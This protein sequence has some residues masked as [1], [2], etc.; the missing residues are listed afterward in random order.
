MK[1]IFAITTL[2][3][4]INL[5]AQDKPKW[6]VNIPPGK[7][8]EVS[9]TANE[10]TWMNLD[11]SPDGSTIAFDM[12]GDIYTMPISGG[13]A[14]AIRTGLAWEVQPRW[15]PDG[16]K[17]LF[18][19]DS[20]GGDNI[21][22]MDADGNNVKQITKESFRLLNNA[23][24]MPDGQYIIAR[25][26]FTSGR[27][28]GAGEMWMYHISGGDGIQ[29]TKR[30]NDQQDV[31]E[32]TISPDG[33]MLYYSE[34]VY[35]GGYFQ[36]NK[37]PNSEIFVI[38]SYN[39]ETGE[40]KRVTGGPGGACRPQISNKGDKIAYV[41]RVREKS[42]LYIYEIST[43]REWAIYDGL[44]KDQQEAWTVFGIY[45]GFDWMP[46]DKEIVIWAKGKIIKI[47][48]A[49]KKATDIPFT[50]N[51]KHK[52]METVQFENKA[53]EE[54]FDLKVLRNAVTSPDGN[55]LVFS[56][57]G[58]LYFSQNGKT[59]ERL[60][61]GTDFEAEPQFNAKGDQIVYV[62]WNDESLGKI[63]IY[64]LTTKKSTVV[65]NDPAI[66]RTPS[67][68]PDGRQIVYRK[69]GGNGHQGYQYNTNSGIYTAVV[70]GENAELI[71]QEG[72]K[73]MFSAD[74]SEIFFTTGGFLFGSIAKAFKKYSFKT[75]KTEV[76][77]NTSYTTNF[78]PSPDN[79]WV[80]FT[81]LYK[82]YIAPMPKTGQ[83]IGLSAKTKA[84]P[85]AQVARDAGIN[86]HW[87]ADSKSLHWTLGNEYFTES[88]NRRFLFLEGA[89]D[90]IP[91]IDT[92]GTKISLTIKTDKP[93]GKIAF[94]NA[95]II[96][97]ENDKVIKNGIVLV[98]ENIIKYVGP[99]S[100]VKL[101]NNTKT[102]DVKGKTIMPG[103]IDVHAHLGAFRDGIS[104]QKHWEYFANL[105]Y[106]VTTTH[107]PSVNSEITFA[108]SEMVK[109]GVL[110]GPRIFSTGTILYGA[111][112]DFK[113]EINSLEDAKSALRRTKAFGAFSVKSYNQP[114]REQRQQVIEAA[115][116]L[117][118]RVVPEGGSFF[119]HNM[120]MVADGHTSVE[121]NIPV[122]PLYKD[123]VNFW[124]NTKTSNTPTLI[125]NY[126]GLTGEYYWYQNTEVWKKEKLLKYTPRSIIDSRSR[127]RTMVPQEEYENGHILTSKSCKKLADAG[128][129][130]NLGA[131]G[132][133]QGLGAHWELW[134]LQ[135]GGMSNY[136]A[137]KSATVN[138]A[139]LLG[140]EKQIGTL[141]AG[142]LADL[143]VIDGNPME[144][145]RKTENVIY[146]MINGRLY[147]TETMDEIGNTSK[148]RTK[149]YW[150]LDGSGLA[151]PFHQ[152]TNGFMG[153]RCACGL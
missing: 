28:L 82:V 15:S 16:K 136:Q 119:Y 41:R 61:T 7:S 106:G 142:K 88:L 151:Y 147:D 54:E 112:G 150:E 19:S 11:V 17:I 33:K 21:F 90:S 122:A 40:T 124:S 44:S 152:E 24:W 146:T 50:V 45:T 128:V 153:V 117:G 52:L 4:S 94:K 59:P 75:K 148:K 127:H 48:I 72:E 39:M 12:L 132:Q 70:N 36:Y 35:P 135:Q 1:H 68:S 78:V 115:R 38:N 144:D 131:H 20:A 2:F 91:P 53:Y 107:D 103:L 133:L 77:F 92:V 86:L 114:R 49:D 3:F 111:D 116:Q 143:I 27:S 65:T 83:P 120:S 139:E 66:Y 5:F 84:V 126:G 137:L 34:D 23:V 80:A 9:F 121:H 105:A 42:V 51:A 8:K 56:A 140:M 29:L 101:D 10:G 76:V 58:S 73:P 18:T 110:T 149:F 138:G 67:F 89:L 99:A 98:E 14:T 93:K 63:Q 95:N 81:E 123:V 141:K 6:D 108:Q 46:D 30:K 130:I 87:S 134:M 145:I 104:P 71:T 31:N 25:K 47:N 62:T 79:K 125:V 37:D 118:I 13:T 55:R 100:G 97:M 69:E 32:P 57:L 113:A 129:N 96:T 64:N 74:G 60:T 109:A 22:Y 102:I 85:V 26:H 43:G